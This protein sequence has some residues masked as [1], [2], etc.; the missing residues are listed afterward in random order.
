MKPRINFITLPT[1]DLQKSFAFYRDGLGLA[2]K[3]IKKGCEDHALFNLNNGLKL[4]LYERKEFLNLN[5]NRGRIPASAGFIISHFAD[6]KE[7]VED[8]LQKALLAG[9]KRIGKIQ[10][11]PWWYAVNFTDLDG[12]QWEI[13]WEA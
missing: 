3:G 13:V 10:D 9:A 2:T 12:H 6:S 4:V 5:G 7:E 8:I 11:E 1:S